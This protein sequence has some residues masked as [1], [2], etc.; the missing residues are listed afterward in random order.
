[1]AGVPEK[2]REDSTGVMLHSGAGARREAAG[3]LE[4]SGEDKRAGEA[5]ALGGAAERIS[6]SCISYARD[7][8]RA[9][10]GVQEVL[11]GGCEEDM[12]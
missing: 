2:S 1:M 7:R 9:E 6:G 8:R 12:R 4:R 5:G 11:R 10:E 3:E